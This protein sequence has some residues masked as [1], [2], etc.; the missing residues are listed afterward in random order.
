MS[1]PDRTFTISA[2]K[3]KR[4]S[5]RRTAALRCGIVTGRPG[6]IVSRQGVSGYQ[7]TGWL[8]LFAPK[9]TPDDVIAKLNAGFDKA[10]KSPELKARFSEQSITSVGGPPHLAE[11]LLDDDIALWGPILHNEGG[12]DR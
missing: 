1:S 2:A 7:F 12:A 8:S 4:G 10:L 6:E 9:G 5:L 11:R 3:T